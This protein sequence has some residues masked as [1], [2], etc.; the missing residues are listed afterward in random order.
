MS[1]TRIARRYARAL[2]ELCQD[3]GNHAV[4]A[5]Q[6]QG[7]AQAY[8]DHVEFREA[9]R[10]PVFAMADK[11]EIL[12][13]VVTRSMLADTTR[14]FL[15]TMLDMRRLDQ[16]QNVSAAFDEILDDVDGRLRAVVTSAIPIEAGDLTRI[17]TSLERLTSKKIT[18]TS[19][20]DE[21]LLG[22]AR[23]QIGNIVL[24]GSVQSQLNRMRD[25][26]LG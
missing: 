2:A 15:F 21:T 13:Q 3:E 14:R 6:L 12:S 4:I 24:D 10:S 5:K 1:S 18:V 8:E 25:Q 7:F 23:V 16:I 19:A 9:M 17:Q 11:K 20:V 26:L 22:G